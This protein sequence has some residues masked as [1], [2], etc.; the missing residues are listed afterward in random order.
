MHVLG[1]WKETD[2]GEHANSCRFK[3]TIFLQWGDS[4]NH[5]TAV[6]PDLV[7]L[8]ANTDIHICQVQAEDQRDAEI[9][10]KGRQTYR[11]R[12]KRKQRTDRQTR[13]YWQTDGQVCEG[14]A[15]RW[16]CK[17]R[18]AGGAALESSGGSDI[19][20]DGTTGHTTPAWLETVQNR[21]TML[22]PLTAVR[23]SSKDAGVSERVPPLY[24]QNAL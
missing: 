12:L 21:P 11:E 15:G 6:P 17:L 13:L 3:P 14:R 22:L 7:P 9:K 5:F 20:D 4:S 8:T 1:L 23:R 24:Y 2:K 10:D 16:V 18:A 19:W